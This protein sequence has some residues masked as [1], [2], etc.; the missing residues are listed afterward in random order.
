VVA[1]TPNVDAAKIAAMEVLTMTF[2][3]VPFRYPRIRLSA[4]DSAV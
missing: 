2:T 3:I 4:I 1:A